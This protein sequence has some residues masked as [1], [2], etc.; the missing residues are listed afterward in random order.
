MFGGGKVG[1]LREDLKNS[2]VFPRLYLPAA[3][4]ERHFGESLR[5]REGSLPSGK[6]GLALLISC[7]GT[8][9]I[10]R[11]FLARFSY[12]VDILVLEGLSFKVGGILFRHTLA[13]VALDGFVQDGFD[14]KAELFT[15]ISEEQLKVI[16]A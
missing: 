12:C 1:K 2:F 4:L 15:T 8:I 13:D 6:C 7:P 11:Q 14:E 16:P 10:G 5:A 3:Y 9:W